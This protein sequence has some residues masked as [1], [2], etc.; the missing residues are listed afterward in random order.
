MLQKIEAEEENLKKRPKS[1]THEKTVFS[2]EN[3]L[4]GRT[5]RNGAATL[6][7]PLLDSSPALGTMM[8][9]LV[10]KWYGW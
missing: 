10:Y 6:V 3:N 9:I 2:R 1:S 8:A 4:R 5:P 7:N